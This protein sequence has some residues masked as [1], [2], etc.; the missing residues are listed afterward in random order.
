[1]TV[2]GERGLVWV[3]RGVERGLGKTTAYG[4]PIPHRAKPRIGKTGTDA[5]MP[6]AC[7]RKNVA[8]R[9]YIKLPSKGI[10]PAC[11]RGAGPEMGVVDLVTP[12]AA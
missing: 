10:K 9:P 6:E 12:M 11:L 3:F 4:S 2:A 1:M 7:S 5:R 8:R